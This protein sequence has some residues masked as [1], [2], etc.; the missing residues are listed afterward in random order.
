[1]TN[2]LDVRRQTIAATGKLFAPAGGARIAYV[3]PRDVGE[4]AAAALADD[5]HDGRAYAL[6]GPRG[7]HLR[8]DRAGPSLAL[9]RPIEYVDVPDDVAREAMRNAGLPPFVA[10]ADHRAVPRPARAG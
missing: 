1:M 10:D 6:T 9:G 5:G 2:L 8:A 3:D 4:A 7:D